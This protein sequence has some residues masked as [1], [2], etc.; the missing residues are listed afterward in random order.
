M[1]IKTSVHSGAFAFMSFIQG[2]VDPRTGQFTQTLTL[3]DVKTNDL[4]GPGLPLALSYNPLNTEDSGWG[5]GWN[6]R[7]SQYTLAD[8][9]VSLS[10]GETFKVTHRAAMEMK[11]EEKKLDSF[12]LFEIDSTH[13]RLVHNTGLV[14][15]LEVM[16]SAQ[17][18]VAM[19]VEIYGPDG[20]KVTL[21]YRQ[22]NALHPMLTAIKDDAGNLLLSVERTDFQVEIQLLPVSAPDG[23]P[24]ATFLMKLIGAD[25]RVEQIILPT[26]ELASWRFV[27]LL[28]DDY[29]VVTS[30]E[31]PTGGREEFIYGDAGHQFPASSTRK[32]LP[33]VTRHRSYPG[34]GQPEIDTRYTYSANLHN[35]LGY[36]LAFPWTE[37]GRDNLYKHVG[38]YAYGSTETLH[39]NNQPVRSIEREFNQF[40]LL[41]KEITTQNDN[42][43]TVETVYFLTPGASFQAQP[44][45][46]QLPKDTH[47]RWSLLSNPSRIR[48]ETVSYTYDKDGNVLTQ[49]QANGVKETSTWLAATEDPL[50]FVRHLNDKTITPAASPNGQAPTL[51]TRYTYTTL[52]PVAGAPIS[53]W[54]MVESEVLEQMN[55]ATPTELERTDYQM[56]DDPG[57]RFLHGRIKTQTVTMNGKATSTAYA[58][59]K[60]N[61]PELNESVLQTRET[62]TGFD[63]GLGGRNVQKVTILEHSLLNGEPLLN[64]DDTN[65]EIRYAYDSLRRV[66]RETVAPGTA[67]EASRNYEYALCANTGDQAE[68]TM[69]DVKGVHTITRFDGLNRAIYEQRDDA[70]NPVP[71]SPPRQIYEALYDPFDRLQ[72]E[73]E[74]DWLGAQ[75]LKLSTQY[76]YD[77]WGEERV[78][79]GPDGVRNVEEN[80]PIGTTASAGPIQRSWRESSDTTPVM[81]G[82]TETWF[83]LFE[84][85]VRIERFDNAGQRVSL[86]Q[87]LYDGLG[88]THKES[89]G[90]GSMIRDTLYAYD[91]FDRLIS[92][93]LPDNAVVKREFAAHSREDLPVL[94]SVD[95][96]VLGEQ[97]FDGLDRRIKTITGGRVQT[98][99]YDPGETEPKTVTTPDNKVIEYRYETRLGQDPVFRRM[100]SPGNIGVFSESSY[101][102]DTENA[103][104]LACKEQ[105]IALERDYFS[106][107][108]PKSEKRTVAG[109][110]YT[111]H[112]RYSRLGRL[113]AYTDVLGQT[114]S[115]RYDNAGRLEHTELG[116]TTAQFTY[117]SF[118]RDETIVTRD[119]ASN[120]RVGMTLDYDEFDRETLR[121]F[122]LDGT[123]QTMHQQYNDV[124]GLAQRTLAEGASVLRDETY[125][126]DLRGR[127]TSY[128]CTGSELPVDPYGKSITG[129]TFNF[130]ALD[131]LTLVLTNFAGG[132][133]RAI[134]AYDNPDKT[135]LTKVTNN[136]VDYPK[137]I[138]LAYNNDG[139]L[140]QDEALRTLDY[141]AL[142]RLIKVSEPAGGASRS[143]A[144]DPLDKLASMDDGTA[145]AQRFYSDGKLANQ[146]EGANSSTFMRGDESMLAELRVGADPKS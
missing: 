36:G 63:H 123:L 10:S 44:N 70:D 89:V 102:Y 135:Q 72:Q 58:Y 95:A 65:V 117:D 84:K 129:Q 77:D 68:Q 17:R 119:S 91:A 46:C 145:Q 9:V 57:D 76:E 13:F 28:K 122:D 71:G 107:G 22:F 8:Q 74:F 99:E 86:T 131:N 14:E 50:G 85:P 98:Y 101:D 55:G 15:I 37:D 136:H 113:E 106:T 139:H 100:P 116:T 23:G 25:R 92:N 51:R 115:Y 130:N 48:S 60:L 88:R 110:E 39:V 79:I 93:T 21:E 137:E 141:D 118:G 12:H 53:D 73:S 59:Q 67:F 111:M 128:T 61:G 142:G 127:L 138:V 140:T 97:E 64:R 40:H 4:N 146:L 81:G 109:N 33:R 133:N 49:L 31:T 3:P 62:L 87:T 35:F 2:G 143:H 112:Y 132:T 45:Y 52:K 134:Y 27:Y 108:E 125:G 41:T 103:R 29:L 38:V 120:Q 20:R 32:P 1:T 7:L 5:L 105:D 26:E 47:T 94:I 42:M 78:V 96:N 80:D 124:D 82:V 6:L 11:M 90:F 69:I 30:M 24:V 144:Y 34:F 75:S 126:Y 56:F 16:G 66:T 18:R 19:P 104:L 114:Q 83:N 54:M 121:T 43:H